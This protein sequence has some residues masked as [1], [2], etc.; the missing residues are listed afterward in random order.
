MNL[1]GI[2]ID[3]TRDQRIESNSFKLLKDY[4]MLP[5][6]TLAQEA[7]ARAS[8]AYCQDDLALAQ[9]IYDYASA[10]WFMFASPVLSNAPI[11]GQPFKTMPISCFLTYVPDSLEG[12]IDHSTE[13][14]W[15]SVKGGGV[16]GHWSAVRAVSDKAPGPIPFLKTVDADMSAYRQGRCYS[17]DTEILTDRGWIAF[18]Q[19]NKDDLVATVDD[20]RIITFCQP[21]ELVIEKHTGV[22]L[23]LQDNKNLDLLVTPDHSMVINRKL[24]NRNQSTYYWARGIEKIRAQDLPLHSEVRMFHSGFAS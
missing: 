13:L 19:L 15:L 24:R 12:L 4:Y 11:P 6:E 2:T 18:P 17:P 7:F 23:H 22:L 21:T 8:V 9:R 20:K 5:Q 16:G 1:Y 10:G 3:P 14:R